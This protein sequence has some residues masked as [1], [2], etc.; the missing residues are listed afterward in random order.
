MRPS[1]LS[2]LLQISQAELSQMRHHGT[3]PQY[4]HEA[5]RVHYREGDVINFVNLAVRSTRDQTA[6]P[7]DRIPGPLMMAAECGELLN[8]S[9]GA[10]GQMRSQNAG[11]R[12][13]KFGR[14]VRYAV[15]DVA[16][17]VLMNRD[18]P[19]RMGQ[20]R[21]GRKEW[22]PSVNRGTRLMTLAELAAAMSL[23][24]KGLYSLRA[25]QRG[26]HSIRVGSVLRFH[27]DDVERWIRASTF[28]QS[29]LGSGWS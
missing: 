13:L 29:S 16:D 5:R 22:T 1:A 4:F 21:R 14:R 8:V 27:P 26:P 23:S 15:E 12:F 28:D 6:A 9:P 3:G 25:D 18:T 17:F 2:D 11:P 20:R 7:F 19:P 24:R 10:L